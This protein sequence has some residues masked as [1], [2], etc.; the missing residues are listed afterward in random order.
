MFAD[1]RK[2]RGMS[3][4]AAMTSD[5][6]ALPGIGAAAGNSDYFAYSD[7]T[8]IAGVPERTRDTPRI[9]LYPERFLLVVC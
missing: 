6:R 1:M 2:Q 4:I 9:F 7:A 5:T 8:W 3:L